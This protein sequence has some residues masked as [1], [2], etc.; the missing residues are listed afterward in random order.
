MARPR[1]IRTEDGGEITL[2]NVNVEVAEKIKSLLDGGAPTEVTFG[3]TLSLKDFEVEA[4]VDISKLENVALGLI[5][6]DK[7]WKVAIIKFDGANAVVEKLINAGDEKGLAVER[8]K[9]L[10]V[11]HNL[12]G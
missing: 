6:Q 11:E 12:V 10:A 8:F 5:K 1:V 7:V 4:P 9:I 3:N 2:K